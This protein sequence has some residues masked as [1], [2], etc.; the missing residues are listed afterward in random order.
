MASE[1]TY[2]HHH[3]T[4]D[5]IFL[6]GFPRS[7][8]TLLD[9]L[10]SGHPDIEVIEEKDP[11]RRIEN[12]LT[13]ERSV[14]IEAFHKLTLEQIEYLRNIYYQRIQGLR[15]TSSMLF[16]DKLPLHSI[17]I[18]LI[19]ILFPNA[20]IIFSV[21]HP[22][23]VALSCFQQVF[24]PNN[25]MANFT[26]LGRTVHLYDSVMSAWNTYTSNLSVD[27]ITIKY[28]ELVTN[29]KRSLL[30]TTIFLGIE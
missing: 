5:P 20:K 11:L 30:E 27:H 14:P 4:K 29:P 22:Y 12:F 8:T 18:P 1:T 25:A 16:I 9:T 26:T 15:Q 17:A 24:K 23:D 13:Q 10:L 2:L 6:V 21:R 28:E 7:G 19:K 3:S